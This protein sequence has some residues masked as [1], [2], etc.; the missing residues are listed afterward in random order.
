MGYYNYT[1]R[2]KLNKNTIKHTYIGDFYILN[3]PMEQNIHTGNAT[4]S[5]QSIRN[6]DKNYIFQ[7]YD[8]NYNLKSVMI[9]RKYVAEKCF[10][11]CKKTLE[12]NPET[13]KEEIKYSFVCYGIRIKD[14]FKFGKEINI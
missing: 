5:M 8:E 3:H 1:G 13:N 4:F 2:H 10:P 12:I 14:I 7:Y 6:Y 9:G 11:L